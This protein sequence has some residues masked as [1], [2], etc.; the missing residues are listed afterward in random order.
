MLTERDFAVGPSYLGPWDHGESSLN[1]IA[2]LDKVRGQVARRPEY[3]RS[4]ARPS[5]HEGTNLFINCEVVNAIVVVD[6]A[7]T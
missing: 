2:N 6:L 3:R 5:G 7:V 1:L 4:H